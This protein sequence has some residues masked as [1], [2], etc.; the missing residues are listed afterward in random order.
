MKYIIRKDKKKR[1][2][3][4]R[5]EIKRKYL[6]YVVSNDR[7]TKHIRINAMLQ[8]NKL[9][10]SSARVRIRNRCVITGRSKSIYR[11]FRMSR[12]SLRNFAHNGLLPGILK[13]S[14]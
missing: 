3:F 9:P 12:L 10:R 1:D 8:L 13:S 6:K 2:L 4:K 14:W 11:T 5:Y 7:V